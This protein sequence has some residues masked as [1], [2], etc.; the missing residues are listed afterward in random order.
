MASQTDEH[1]PENVPIIW[2]TGADVALAVMLLRLTA[3]LP[4]RKKVKVPMTET[5]ASQGIDRGDEAEQPCQPP[6]QPMKT[7]PSTNRAD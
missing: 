7:P 1:K 2:G 4:S 6:G 5:G 3:C